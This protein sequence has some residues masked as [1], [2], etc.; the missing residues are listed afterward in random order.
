MSESKRVK[1]K[2]EVCGHTANPILNDSCT[3]ELKCPSCAM[4]EMKFV[5][6][7]PPSVDAAPEV[8]E[9]APDPEHELEAEAE[10]EHPG[11]P[12]PEE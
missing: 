2:C 5:D 11:D 7:P 1:M 12:P 3:P 4:G 8:L 10:E 6:A 9:E